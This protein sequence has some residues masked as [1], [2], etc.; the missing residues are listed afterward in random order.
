MQY[1]QTI[2]IGLFAL[3]IAAARPAAL[4]AMNNTGENS[5]RIIH[6]NDI[7]AH[8][9]P[10]NR[11]GRD[12]SE[13][14]VKSGNC[15]GGAAR[16]VTTV[17]QL[18]NGHPNSLLFD[19]GD[20]AQ[21]TLFYT[22]GKFNTTIKVM[23]QLKYDA[24]CIGNHEF[25]DG[26][27][28][29]AEFFSKI[30]FPAICANIDMT[31]N[32]RLKSVVKPYI[33]FEKYKL[34]VIGYITNTT[35][36]ISQAGPTVSFSNAAVAVNRYVEELR[37]KGI[38]RIIAV[39][40]N[41]YH[42]DI[43]VATNTRGLD[44]IVGGHSHTYL[45]LNASE[46]GAG[47]LYPTAVK[48]LDGQTTYVVQAKA[49]GEYVGY[50]DLVF[51]SDG[52]VASISGEP[53]HM[54]QSISED[55]IMAANVSEWRRPFE[56]YGKTVVG[57]IT[58][59]TGIENCPQME[60]AMGDLTTD[61]MLWS[62]NR[63]QQTDMALLTSGTIRAGLSAGPVTSK[64]LLLIYPFGDDIVRITISGKRLRSIITGGFKMVNLFN[65]R[66]VI[67]FIQISGVRVK[68][69]M[70]PSNSIRYSKIID[71]IEISKNGVLEVLDDTRTY[72]L[73]TIWHIARGMDN[74]IDPPIDGVPLQR[75]EKAV[76]EYLQTFSP[77]TPAT[78]GRMFEMLTE[79]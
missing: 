8:Y 73:A 51:N 30:N 32:P 62:L 56:A 26:P 13:H 78:D 20:Q 47:G 44:L 7:H 36:N 34:G 67:K 53:I 63:I 38:K 23:N 43:D 71:S 2:T 66:P 5:L 54:T 35:G 52:S 16:L 77:V 18:R 55:A 65:G 76:K 17:N 28:L 58:T 46:P 57:N 4:Q 68:Y 10:F 33:V 11:V 48:N 70:D 19:A 61:A 24:M 50:V 14:D 1:I 25:D 60:C 49:W 40:H 39:S 15:F 37:A 27:D 74:V 42:E 59:E 3:S 22:I 45:S 31:K 29:L 41:G 64:D 9:S 21:G 75:L 79:V 72:S 69:H 12:C 6:T